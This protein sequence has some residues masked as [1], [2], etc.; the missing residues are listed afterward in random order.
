ML[1]KYEAIMGAKWH[2]FGRSES[3]FFGIIVG[4]LERVRGGLKED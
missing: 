4:F 2:L 3:K 1:L